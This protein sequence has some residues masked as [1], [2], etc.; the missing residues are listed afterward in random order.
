MATNP[1]TTVG[2]RVRPTLVSP[3]RRVKLRKSGSVTGRL[4]TTAIALAVLALVLRYLPPGGRNAQA[5]EPRAA[6]NTVPEDL[7]FSDVQLSKAPG[8]E[9][10]YLDGLVTNLGK[11]AVSGATAEVN[12]L[13]SQ[14]QVI[15][16]VQKPLVG[17]AHGGTDLVQDEFSRNPITSK[18]MRFF[19]VAVEPVPS[20]WNHELPTLK[21]VAV[22]VR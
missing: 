11:A 7:Q 14:G 16:S 21:I 10:L 3:R 5:H 8:G 2:E 1:R 22:H 6:V 15:A 18:Q 4:L 17:M 12:F 19:R 20:A 13:N 9:V